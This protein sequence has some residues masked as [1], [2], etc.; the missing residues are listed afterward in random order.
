MGSER[1]VCGL[2]R[3]TAALRIVLRATVNEF[4]K[5]TVNCHVVLYPYKARVDKGLKASGRSQG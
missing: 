4:V 2:I 1:R 3:F 5:E